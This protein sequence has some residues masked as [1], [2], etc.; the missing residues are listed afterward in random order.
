MAFAFVCHHNSFVIFTSLKNPTQKRWNTTT[1]ASLI[2]SVFWSMWL[3]I[4]GFFN[5]Q[6]ET[7]GDILNNF[8][9]NNSTINFARA[10]LALTMVFT[11]PMELV[12]FIY[13]I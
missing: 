7:E 8:S 10:L 1:H 11:Y 13:L 2:I 12:M 5:F 3:A 9:Y 4:A 6:Q